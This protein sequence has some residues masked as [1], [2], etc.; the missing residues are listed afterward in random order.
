MEIKPADILTPA[1]AISA[2]GFAL[3]A[4][5]AAHLGTP[6]GL[7]EVGVGRTLD[8]VD[9]PVARRTGTSE[10]GVAVDATL[11][12]LG[13][14]VVMVEAWQQDIMP[15]SV[16]VA[17]AAHNAIN[18]VASVVAAWRHPSEPMAPSRSGKYAMAAENVA[19]G[20][21]V[22]AN[23]LEGNEQV[24]N[25]LSGIGA[26]ATLAGVGVLGTHATYGYLRRAFAPRSTH[27]TAQ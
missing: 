2:A 13:V 25:L 23:V 24:S 15:K 7:A 16:L 12:K 3:T 4:F 5:G 8:L 9:G 1:N 18:A 22:L 26:I 27:E 10:F 17:I 11:D 20:G 14:G 21:Y 6:L 19:L